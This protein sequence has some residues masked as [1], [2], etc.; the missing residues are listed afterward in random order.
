MKA[1][2]TF[3]LANEFAPWRK[4]RRFERV[5]G[6]ASDQTYSAQVG[7]ADVRV[8]LTGVG[9][10]ATQRALARAFDWGADVCIA[11]GLSGG[12]RSVHRPGAVLAARIVANVDQTR[13]LRSDAELVSRAGGL[14]AKVVERFL[15]SDHVVSTSEEKEFLGASGDAVDMESAYVLSAAAQR[16]I[17]SAAIRAISDAVESDLPLD[18]GQAFNERGNVSVPKVIGQIVA[19]PQRIGGLLQLAQ[20]SERAAAALAKFLDEYVQR[21]SEGPLPEIPKAEALAT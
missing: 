8:V 4:S 14:G 16:G 20:E 10:F 2:I 5:S 12:L 6:D 19:R 18:F 13:L 11:S 15:T 21:I 9:R 7:L 3:A 17:P 1:L